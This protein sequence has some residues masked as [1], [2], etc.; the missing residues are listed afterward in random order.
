MKHRQNAVNRL[1]DG[2]VHCANN[3]AII[4]PAEGHLLTER[5]ARLERAAG[6]L[7]YGL[8]YD[9]ELAMRSYRLDRVGWISLARA[10]VYAPIWTGDQY[11]R[12][13]P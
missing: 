9:R 2:S 13:T 4:T 8:D 7:F 3:R 6:V 1:D 5:W 11:T 10:A 12:G